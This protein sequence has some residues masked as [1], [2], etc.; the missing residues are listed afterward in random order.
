MARGDDEDDEATAAPDGE[1]GADEAAD[2]KTRVSGDEEDDDDDEDDEEDEEDEEDN[3]DK[4]WMSFD[5]FEEYTSIRC[6]SHLKVEV[7]SPPL[8]KVRHQLSDYLLLTILRNVSPCYPAVQPILPDLQLSKVNWA[9][10]RNSHVKD[11]KT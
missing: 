9:G 2:D 1:D 7:P 3:E 8:H 11:N 10:R 4:E 5:E 6:K